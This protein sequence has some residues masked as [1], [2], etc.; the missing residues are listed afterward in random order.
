MIG[1][2]MN[3]NNNNAVHKY[4]GTAYDKVREVAD[5]LPF[6]K[7]ISEALLGSFKYLGQFQVMNCMYFLKLDH[8]LVLPM[9]VDCDCD[10]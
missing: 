6:L 1:N 3:G 2:S 4:I 8:G 10:S 5:N 9:L 7:D